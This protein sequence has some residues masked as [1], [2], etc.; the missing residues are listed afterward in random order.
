MIRAFIAIEL[1]DGLRGQI[2]QVQRELQGRLTREAPA[3]RLAWVKPPSMHLTL[4]FLG[5]IDE[6]RVE[7]L[8]DAI[9]QAVRGREPFEV[10]LARIGAFPRPQ[11][12]RSLWIGAPDAWER[13]DDAQR[14]AAL[15]RAIEEA[16][17]ADGVPRGPRPFTPHLT[18]ARVKA[19]ER[20]V[21]RAL[22]A[23]GAL[24]RPLALE[25][26]AVT[27]LSF[28]KSQLNSDGAVHTRLWDLPLGRVS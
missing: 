10:P 20:H 16:C 19:G 28:M 26:L 27:T 23:T 15:V 6:R 22:A 4:K 1:P 8:R 21:G 17:A 5:E 12:P 9:A 24:D 14:L 11:E 18:L 13:G 2:A 3:A 25:P 7:A